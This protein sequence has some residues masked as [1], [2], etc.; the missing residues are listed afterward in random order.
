M[1]VLIYRFFFLLSSFLTQMPWPED[2]R[3]CSKHLWSSFSVRLFWVIFCINFCCPDLPGLL[4]PSTQLIGTAGLHLCFPPCTMAQNLSVNKPYSYSSLLQTN[5]KIRIEN[6]CSVRKGIK[7][8]WQENKELGLILW[9]SQNLFSFSM[10]EFPQNSMGKP[11]LEPTQDYVPFQKLIML[12]S[13]IKLI[14]F[15]MVYKFLYKLG[16]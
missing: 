7:Y 12:T 16:F 9:N 14:I 3:R 4:A 10:D 11:F 13:N 15:L 8:W 1:S 6:L 5:N 2:K